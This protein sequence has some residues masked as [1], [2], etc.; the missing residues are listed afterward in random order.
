M[1]LNEFYSKRV[2]ERVNAMDLEQVEKFADKIF[3]KVGIDVEFT[4]HFLDRIND[5]R[6]G[7]P[8]TPSELTRIFRQEYK[9]W[10]KP[11]AQMGSNQQA[12]MKDLQTDINIPF[13]LVWDKTNNE[14]DLVAKTIMRKKEFN[15]PN[16]TYPVEGKKV[17][18]WGRVVKGV[19]TT[20]DVGKN[21]IKKQA[22]K[23]GN[24]VDKDGNPP[25]LSKKV[26]GSKTN[27]LHNLGLSESKLKELNIPRNKMPQI[28]LKDLQNNYDLEHDEVDP[29]T[30]ETSQNQRIPGMVDKTVKSIENGF[31]KP[32]VIDQNGFIVNGHH[33]YDAYLRLEKEAVPVI[34]VKNASIQ[35]LVR[36]FSHT[37]KDTYAET[38]KKRKTR[39]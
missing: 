28:S 13:A 1:R 16:K 7:K 11:I 30:L 6:N 31:D 21:E 14:L 17:N 12:V 22:A 8:I 34:R 37:A 35:E 32:L 26:K 29:S 5:E 39:Q 3:G 27:I 19:N 4:R 25:T 36:D 23:F 24:T 15:T 18:E 33:R 10:G 20:A 2:N 9:K 38:K